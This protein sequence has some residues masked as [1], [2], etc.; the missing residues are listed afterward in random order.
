MMA[1]VGFYGSSA[2]PQTRPS[3]VPS[4]SQV[5]QEV[6]A[7]LDQMMA[8]IGGLVKGQR[9]AQQ[10]IKGLLFFCITSE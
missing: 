10:S 6:T 8:M 4:T 7:K 9:D 5:P 1:N 2:R 3:E